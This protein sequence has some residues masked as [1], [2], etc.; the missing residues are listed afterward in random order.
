[1]KRALMFSVILVAACSEKP[2]PKSHLISAEALRP[3]P[4]V[5]KMFIDS[6]RQK[7][8]ANDFVRYASEA[9]NYT[10]LIVETGNEYY[11]SFQL[12]P[13]GKRMTLD[14]RIVFMVKKSDWSV[15]PVAS[16]PKE[17]EQAKAGGPGCDLKGA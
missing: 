13:Y 6:I 5:Y 12:K 4:V 10:L 15:E 16:V 17:A 1:M 2:V 9:D 14:G 3:A 11:Y 8:A 7:D